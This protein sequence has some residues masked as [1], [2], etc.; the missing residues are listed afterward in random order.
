MHILAGTSGFAYKEW[1]GSF[2]PQGLPDRE[3]LSYYA[4]QFDA[5]EINSTFYRM[6]SPSVLEGWA[7]QTPGHF[8]FVLK[9]SRQITHRKRLKEVGGDV[10]Y[11]AGVARTLGSRLGPILFQLP[12]YLKQ[13]LA[14]L[15][16]FL[17]VLPEG[18]AAALEV[19]SASWLDD[20]VYSRLEAGGVAL[21][22]SDTT[23]EKTP[24]A[25][26]VPTTS[27][28]YARLRRA[29]YTDGELDAWLERFRAAGWE[30]LNVFFKHE[31][32]GTGP[33]LARRFLA[34]S[35]GEDGEGA[36][37]RRGPEVAS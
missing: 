12:P 26:V 6:P 23:E 25:V 17:A 32:E 2:Y 29:T 36:E 9:A 28:G 10:E 7:H 5:V 31:D 8:R 27:W 20:Q 22:V 4:S 35:G 24:E 21:V 11:L 33:E 18:L 30:E 37:S 1:K 15:D 16:D 34:R 19:R 13:D 14:L 3:M